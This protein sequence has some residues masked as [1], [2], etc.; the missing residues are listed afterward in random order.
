MDL[1]TIVKRSLGFLLVF[2]AIPVGLMGIYGGCFLLGPETF[3]EKVA[4][5]LLEVF[6]IVTSSVL[7]ASLISM[8]GVDLLGIDVTS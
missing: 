7:V 6:L 1:K 5:V 4:A 8:L 3:W 2:I